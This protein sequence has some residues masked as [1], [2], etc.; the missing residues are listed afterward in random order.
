MKKTNMQWGVIATAT[1]A[2]VGALASPQAMAKSKAKAPASEAYAAPST[3]SRVDA[4][5]AQLQAMQAEL[6]SL[7]AS[8]NRPSAEAAKVQ[9]LDEWAQSVKA[10]P[11]EAAKDHLFAVRGGW[12]HFNDNRD[13]TTSTL[14]AVNP[15]F[16]TDQDAHY[17][18]G[19][20]DFNV[21]NDLFGLMKNTSFALELGVEY[22]QIGQ[23]KP[24][25]L[26]A[27]ANGTSQLADV[28]Q[29]RISASPKV[30]FLHGSKFRPWLIPAG[31]D[32]NIISPPSSAITVLNTGMQFG[33]GADYELF[34]GIVIGADGRYHHSFDDIDGADTDGFTLG[35]SVGFKF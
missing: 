7:R 20:I 17:Y 34:K 6:S 24:N 25:G 31:L 4:L 11:A 27:N 32:I 23:S 21:N 13:S 35:G 16:S 26:G 8:Q 28:N 30:R 9:E 1:V 15:T 19:A 10:K 2:M 29:L 5:E 18:G 14:G 3:N 22:A 33:A 12:M